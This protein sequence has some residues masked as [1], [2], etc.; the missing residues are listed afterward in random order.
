MDNKLKR[1]IKLVLVSLSLAVIV[2]FVFGNVIE[3]SFT[4]SGDMSTTHR[5]TEASDDASVK[6]ATGI[7]Y[8]VSTTWKNDDIERS[9]TFDT[10]FT[11]VAADP[12]G[13]YFNRYVV[14]SSGAGYKHTYR[15]YF[16]DDFSG[17]AAVTVTLNKADLPETVIPVV[18]DNGTEIGEET[19]ADNSIHA[20]RGA[21]S[22]DSLFL[23][24]SRKGN[25]TFQGRIINGETGRP[26][27]EAEAD[28]VGKFF[29]RSYLN[30]SKPP[31]TTEGWLDF[32]ESLDRDMILDKTVPTGV[33]IAPQNGNYALRNNKLVPVKAVAP[34]VNNS[35]ANL[36]I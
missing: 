6:N 29:V 20:Q 30:I 27:N 23:M 33:Y 28:A 2:G 9:R 10:S 8:D 18:D 11:V 7:D 3:E 12:S 1:N 24:D 17:S 36:T 14:K 25:A 4:G 26:V 35:T 22:I 19:V 5:F 34:V 13:R 15:V 31:T 21:E 16:E 32:C